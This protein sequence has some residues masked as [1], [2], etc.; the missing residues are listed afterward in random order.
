MRRTVIAA[1]TLVL[2]L[3]LL[4]VLR[5][6]APALAEKELSVL[7]ATPTP[8]A[9]DGA[10]AEQTS[11]D[12]Q[13]SV[14]V[15]LED[16]QVEEMSM[17]D[18]LW[19]V[20]AAEMPASFESEALK[21]QAVTARTYTV[22]KML[23]GEE[24]HPDADVC[25]DANCCQAYLSP[26]DA[27][28]T[29]GDTAQAYT[30]KLWTAVNET[31]GEIITYQ[32]QPIQAVFFSSSTARTEDAVEVWGS[33]VPYLVGVDSPEGEE[34][35]N[36][37][38]QVTLSAQEFQEIFLDA[39]PQADLSGTPDAWFGEVVLT[40]SGRV[41]SIEVGGVS[42]TGTALRALFSLRSAAFTVDADSDGVT[43]QVTGYGHGVGLSQYGADALAR[44][45]MDYQ[46]IIKW[47]YTGVELTD[48]YET[49]V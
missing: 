12:S 15:L 38:T 17:A 10:E 37:H 29:W 47:Y 16:G 19:S 3:F 45:G 25:T 6:K 8:A 24:N 9:A 14:R 1:V 28:Q 30:E 40:A 31:D 35:P 13:T 33:A 21:A 41:S 22:W 26:E 48:N 27:A 4:P 44:Q 11:R 32:G 49:G 18:Y 39:Y 36:Y 46:E 23:H 34:V 2:L 7:P 43:F 20:T 42:V 5:L